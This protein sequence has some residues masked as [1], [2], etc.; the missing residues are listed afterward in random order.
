MTLTR[1]GANPEFGSRRDIVIWI[2]AIIVYAGA[3]I[4]YDT[5]VMRLP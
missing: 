4:A 1:V 5:L 2:R 3:A